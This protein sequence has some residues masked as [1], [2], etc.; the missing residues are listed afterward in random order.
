D[1][2]DSTLI[3]L[4]SEEVGEEEFVAI[5]RNLAA[6]TFAVRQLPAGPADLLR[7]VFELR[8]RRLIGLRLSGKLAWARDTGAKVRLIDSVE[9]RLLPSRERWQDPI[10][11]L[12]DNL[13]TVLLEW[14]WSHPELKADVAQAFR[15]PPNDDVEA[16]KATFFEIV[17]LW[18][19][20]AAFIDI[21]QRTQLAMDDL[22]AIHT[23][24]VTYALQSLIEQGISLLTRRLQA[25]GIEIAPGVTGFT[26]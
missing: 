11:P 3:D 5:A 22:L 8:A 21:A 15:L 16:V 25:D 13:R 2:V 12:D 20:G 23:R 9:Q 26:E 6:Q 4:I 7:T 1:G 19:A 24:A 10:D 18:V 14:A 17:R